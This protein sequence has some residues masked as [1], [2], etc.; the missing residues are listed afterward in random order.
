M[1]ST[2]PLPVD[3][4]DVST[5]L[6]TGAK[7]PRTEVVLQI[8]SNSSKND[9]ALPPL[10]YCAEEA[11]RG[12]DA[13]QHCVPPN[14]G[15]YQGVRLARYGE[16][17]PEKVGLSCGVLIQGDWKLIW[18]Y[19]GWR[20]EEWNGWIKPP[21]M[22]VEK[23]ILG[24]VQAI[25]AASNSSHG[26]SK[27]HGPHCELDAPC[28]FDLDA[29]PNEH[30]DVATEHPDVVR[31]MQARILELLKGEV[32]LADSG[33]CPTSIGTKP[34]VKMTAKARALGFWVPWL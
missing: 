9:H 25:V 24:S 8:V 27:Q 26:I 17:A 21:T 34:D 5:A 10:A 2:G 18:G 31:K 6:L 30:D 13:Y 32:T 7:S 4:V 28:L 15:I 11:R 22:T 33:L 20:N 14:G 16:R 23:T 1:D 19:P 12:T 29:D 3:G